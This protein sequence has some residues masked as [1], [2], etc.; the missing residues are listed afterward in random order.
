[1]ADQST[2]RDPY[3]YTR[4]EPTGIPI[5]DTADGEPG[6]HADATVHETAKIHETAT[7]RGAR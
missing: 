5:R 1:M 7:I 2:E 3:Q 4:G 6:I